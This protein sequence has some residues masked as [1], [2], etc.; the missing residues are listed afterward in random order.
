M[1]DGYLGFGES[2]RGLNDNSALALVEDWLPFVVG[3]LLLLTGL[4][5]YS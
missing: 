4:L 1:G 2:R 3:A 5:V